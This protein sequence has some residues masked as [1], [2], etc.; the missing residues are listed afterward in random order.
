MSRLFVKIYLTILAS[1]ALLVLIVGAF[2][3]F[4]SDDGRHHPAV[5]LVVQLAAA[6]LSRAK[7]PPADQQRAIEDLSQ[8]L[9]ADLALYSANGQL[10]AAAGRH[11]PPPP[12]QSES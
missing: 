2:W 10:M 4:S 3:H 11:L 9:H 8:H 12:G 5:G 6:G 7:A 1:L